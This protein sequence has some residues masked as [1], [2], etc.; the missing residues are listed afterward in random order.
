MRAGKSTWINEKSSRLDDWTIWIRTGKRLKNFSST[1]VY[2]HSC[3]VYF[4][5]YIASCFR[6]FFFRYHFFEISLFLRLKIILFFVTKQ[7]KHNFKWKIIIVLFTKRDVCL[8]LL[9]PLT[10]LSSR[11]ICF[12]PNAGDADPEARINHFASDPNF[13]IVF[14]T[15]YVIVKISLSV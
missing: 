3:F 5:T 11:P 12:L 15:E 9:E 2:E 4:L 10:S 7:N 13:K 14:R 8:P 6:I 1:F